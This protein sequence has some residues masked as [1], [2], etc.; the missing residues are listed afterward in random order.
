MKLGLRI[1]RFFY[2]KVIK[3]NIKKV[4]K[5]ENSLADQPNAITSEDQSPVR[6]DIPLNIIEF[7]EQLKPNNLMNRSTVL[8]MI[9]CIK[10]IHHSYDSLSK[11]EEG[12]K[13]K[14]NDIFIQNL[15]EYC[16]TLGIASIGFTKLPHHLVFKDKAVLFENAIVLTMEMDKDR[17]AIA[18]HRK[19][20]KMIM[21]TYN[22]LGIVA[23]KIASYLR[24]KGYAAQASHPLG[25]VV[26][27][28]P[29]AKEAGLGWFGRHGLLITP[30]FGA[31]V[32][33][34]AVFTNIPNLP[35]ATEN[36]HSWIPKYCATCGKCIKN[37][38]PKAIREQSVLLENG[39]KSHTISDKCFPYF[40][41]NYGCT[42]CI[43]VCP[44]STLGYEKIHAIVKKKKLI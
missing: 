11:N 33:L 41:Q 29:L 18:P 32:R 12:L 43:K 5:K 14:A 25:G 8:P 35:F 16:K 39:L 42:V 9:S 28:P 6:F 38:P 22:K 2:R 20:V 4:Y 26:L 31:R 24:D 13:A 40:A 37:C 36:K 3:T 19:T 44:F 1:K 7:A 34:A 23:N 10:N 15:V 21:Q 17:I 30:E 27:Y